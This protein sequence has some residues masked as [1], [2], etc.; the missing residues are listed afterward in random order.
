[1]DGKQ[2]GIDF[3]LAQIDMF[4][5]RQSVSVDCR[6]EVPLPYSELVWPVIMQDEQEALFLLTK[7][8]FTQRTGNFKSCRELIKIFDLTCLFLIAERLLHTF[9][10]LRNASLC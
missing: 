10:F 8:Q 1:M 7:R 5:Q 9:Y 2:I 3:P 6:I 4:A